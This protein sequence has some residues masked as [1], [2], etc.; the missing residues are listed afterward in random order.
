MIVQCDKCKMFYDDQFRYITCNHDTFSAND[1]QNNFTFYDKSWYSKEMPQ[2][3]I[4]P[5]IIGEQSEAEKYEEWL[6]ANRI[7]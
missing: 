3:F 7:K 5:M 1:G 2:R 6:N 4:N